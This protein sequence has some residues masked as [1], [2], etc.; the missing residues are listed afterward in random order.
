[1]KSLLLT[2]VILF[3]FTSVF[4]Q[5]SVGDTVIGRKNNEIE[6]VNKS[7]FI[8]TY[9]LYKKIYKYSGVNELNGNIYDVFDTYYTNRH[10][11]VYKVENN[12]T[13]LV[14][15]YNKELSTAIQLSINHIEGSIYSLTIVYTHEGFQ[16]Q[17]ISYDNGL[18][19]QF[20]IDFT[21][22]NTYQNK[23]Y[24]TSKSY[25]FR[26]SSNKNNKLLKEIY[27]DYGKE[28]Q[29]QIHTKDTLYFTGSLTYFIHVDKS[30][31]EWD[32][33]NNYQYIPFGVVSFD[34]GKTFNMLTFDRDDLFFNGNRYNSISHFKIEN[35]IFYIQV[36]EVEKQSL[37][38]QSTDG[39]NYKYVGNNLVKN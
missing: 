22:I 2:L 33:N 20:V 35:G 34:G 25:Y 12:D 10:Y 3:T 28:Y 26:I 6:K 18:S 19:W 37:Y 36:N 17:Y 27:F 24:L 7:L 39:I 32:R 5:H 31:N 38:F 16:K 11:D 30:T 29:R 14:F 4:S 8:D 1:M 15:T 9:I 21:D 23:D 13:I